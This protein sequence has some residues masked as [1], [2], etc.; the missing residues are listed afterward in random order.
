MTSSV[1]GGSSP[2]NGPAFVLGPRV[3]IPNG[4]YNQVQCYDYSIGAAC[5][6][7]PR[8]FNNLGY[9]YTVKPDPQRA[10]CI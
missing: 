10:T 8:G 1:I 7:F 6:G 3:Y 4:N 2:W 5:A 9:L